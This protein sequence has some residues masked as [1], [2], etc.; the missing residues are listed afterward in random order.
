M[1]NAAVQRLLIRKFWVRIPTRKPLAVQT[2]I[3]V[4]SL[5]PFRQMLSVLSIY[6]SIL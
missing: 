6:F 1:W 3:V 4:V 2:E 5:T